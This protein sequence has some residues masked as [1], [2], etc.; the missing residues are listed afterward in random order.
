[1]KKGLVFI[2]MTLIVVTI[3]IASYALDSQF[4]PGNYSRTCKNCSML[5]GKLSCFCYNRNGAQQH[6]DL[7]VPLNCIFV[8]NINGHL[9]CT[10]YR[11][12]YQHMRHYWIIYPAVR[13]LNVGPLFS[14][15]DA[16]KRCPMACVRYGMQWTGHWHKAAFGR[17]SVCQCEEKQGVS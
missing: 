5:N 15:R 6:A 17:A 1:M 16:S 10:Y 11:R 3:S 13:N 9:R 14:Q 7:M 2:S 8:E 12:R 4:P